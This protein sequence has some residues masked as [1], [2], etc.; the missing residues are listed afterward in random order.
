MLEAFAQDRPMAE[1]VELFHKFV[2]MSTASARQRAFF[3][4][5]ATEFAAASGEVEEAITAL[6]KSAALPLVDLLWMDKCPV[7]ACLRDDPRFVRARAIVA[8][9]VAEIWA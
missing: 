8:T 6:E 9:R 5:L 2:D 3:Y 1:I 4:Q 7:L